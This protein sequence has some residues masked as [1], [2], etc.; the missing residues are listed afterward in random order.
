M[1][2]KFVF[3]VLGLIF[4]LISI[5]V[6]KEKIKIKNVQTDYVFKPS[7]SMLEGE[8]IIRMYYGSPGYGE[9]TEE[10]KKEYPYI[11]K[12]NYPINIIATKN[13]N[14]NSN[15]YNIS[16]VQLVLTEQNYKI[17]NEYKNKN[18]KVK[19]LL[20]VQFSGHHYTKV[21]LEVIEIVK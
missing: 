11:L 18:I 19:G 20:F 2:K 10:D 13:D 21:L 12:L 5:V 16:E 7:I 17:L 3:T 1:M 4:L 6:L 14:F 9:N 15:V 8:L